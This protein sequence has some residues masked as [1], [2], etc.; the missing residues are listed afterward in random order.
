VEH[1]SHSSR[2]EKNAHFNVL[3]EDM[4][5]P[6]RRKSL[7]RHGDIEQLAH[8][9]PP[10][11]YVNIMLCQMRKA[12]APVR[13]LHSG[14]ALSPVSVEGCTIEPPSLATVLNRLKV[15]SG[16]NP[17]H[18]DS[19]VHGEVQLHIGSQEF[20]LRTTFNDEAK[21]QCKI[22]FLNTDWEQNKTLEDTRQ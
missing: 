4:K 20:L 19:Q 14:E 22:E 10:I 5:T 9:S 13:V 2:C 15:M 8:S 17:V 7:D 6:F 12:H 18:F 21:E 11:R 16:L 1:I 3:Q